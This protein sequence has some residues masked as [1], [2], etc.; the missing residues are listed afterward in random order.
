MV[1]NIKK[2]AHKHDTPLLRAQSTPSRSRNFHKVHL[3]VSPPFNLT[4]QDIVIASFP[5]VVVVEWLWFLTAIV[6]DIRGGYCSSF[7]AV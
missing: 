6:I 3:A 5:F 4:Y 1:D 7:T 2:T